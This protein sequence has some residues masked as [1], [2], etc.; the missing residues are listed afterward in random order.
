[1]VK[2]KEDD[3]CDD[4]TDRH[5]PKPGKEKY[6]DEKNKKQVQPNSTARKTPFSLFGRVL[7]SF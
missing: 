7:L 2:T 1:M 3:P 6:D 5:I 4:W